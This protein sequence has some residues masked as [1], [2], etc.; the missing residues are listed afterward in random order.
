MISIYPIPFFSNFQISLF[1]LGSPLSVSSSVLTDVRLPS[2][3]STPLG[4]SFLLLGRKDGFRNVEGLS[5]IKATSQDDD[6]LSMSVEYQDH[7]I[8]LEKGDNVVGGI[9]STE[10]GQTR[11]VM[12]IGDINNDGSPDLLFGDPLNSRAFVYF[13]NEEG[14]LMFTSLRVSFMITINPEPSTMKTGLGWAAAPLGDFNRDGYDDFIVTAPTV[15]Q[16]YVIYGR[17][18]KRFLNHL[19]LSEIQSSSQGFKIQGNSFVD[20]TFGMAVSEAGDVN[21][22]GYVDILISALTASASSQANVYIIFGN[23]T[24]P[25][26]IDLS[27]PAVISQRIVKITTPKSSFSGFSIAGIGDFNGDGYDDVAIGSAPFQTGQTVSQRTFIIFGRGDF[28]LTKREV[29]VLNA[30]DALTIVGGGF[31]VTSVGDV[32]GD[33][34]NDLMISSYTGWLGKS[35]AYCII[36]PRNI[37]LSVSMNTVT[38]NYQPVK[39]PTSRPSLLSTTSSPSSFGSQLPSTTSGQQSS[40]PTILS[41]R[42]FNFLPT[43]IPT[44]KLSSRPSS[45]NPSRSPTFSPSRK[46]FFFP[47]MRPT[48]LRPPTSFPSFYPSN[49]IAVSVDEIHVSTTGEYEIPYPSTA[50]DDDG[51][52]VRQTNLIL[53]VP[54]SGSLLIGA[55]SN[56]IIYTILPSQSIIIITTFRNNYDLLNLTAFPSVHSLE[57]LQ[58]TNVSS[59]LTLLLPIVSSS[60]LVTYSISMQQQVILLSHQSFDLTVKS[61]LFVPPADQDHHTDGDSQQVITS[62]TT[63]TSALIALVILLFVL[64][65]GFVWFVVRYFQYHTA[66]DIKSNSKISF[67][68]QT[69]HNKDDGLDLE[70]RGVMVKPKEFLRKTYLSDLVEK[71]DKQL[72]TRTNVQNDNDAYTNE[73]DSD[74]EN[75]SISEDEDDNLDD[76]SHEDYTWNFSPSL[77]LSEEDGSTMT[78]KVDEVDEF[79]RP[80]QT[81][82]FD[83]MREFK[84]ILQSS[85]SSCSHLVP[86]H[87]SSLAS[88]FL[89]EVN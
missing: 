43:Y 49:W 33:G 1:L 84:F 72:E 26:V 19:T 75:I 29:N 62:S 20:R 42:R 24:L 55:A 58:Y 34:M 82:D 38:P 36:H 88:S 40:F 61:V 32:N 13:G 4:R 28:L 50:A 51:A 68:K 81:T 17:R 11:S 53:E 39:S 47:S 89:S 69:S 54:T 74:Y 64:S 35:N 22:D 14:D 15:N 37:T 9:Y 79:A 8:L 7:V 78:S 65:I 80:A 76:N 66:E 83:S 70:S 63:Y 52:Q 21:G 46:P 56:R 18:T 71:E 77:S 57:D 16:A 6:S 44:R 27:N 48:I 3:S 25:L 67:V 85:N 59:P 10:N 73:N 30:E 86:S 5:L 45:Q 12:I 31:M 60:S 23:R 2:F 87:A 41:S